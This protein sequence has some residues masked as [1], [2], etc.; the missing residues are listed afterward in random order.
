MFQIV[1]AGPVDDER[2][3]ASLLATEQLIRYIGQSYSEVVDRAQAMKL[4]HGLLNPHDGFVVL[5]NSGNV[6]GTNC[7]EIALWI[8]GKGLAPI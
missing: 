5:D 7:L 2:A 4:A 1:R 6:I 8:N 3:L